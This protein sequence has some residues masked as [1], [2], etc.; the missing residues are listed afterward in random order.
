MGGEA[1]R[2]RIEMEEASRED[3]GGQMVG[4]GGRGGEG[5]GV[6]VGTGG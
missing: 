3:G 6:G 2:G 4:W 5:R 1:D